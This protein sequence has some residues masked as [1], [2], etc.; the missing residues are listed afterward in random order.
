[1]IYTVKNGACHPRLS[2]RILPTGTPIIRATE[3]PTA[4]MLMANLLC[5]SSTILTYTV[6]A[7]DQNTACPAAAHMRDIISIP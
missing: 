3:V 5:C 2:P 1:M 6:M 4:T 7:I